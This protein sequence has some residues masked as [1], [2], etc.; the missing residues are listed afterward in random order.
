MA[1]WVEWNNGPG[2]E[3]WNRLDNLTQVPFDICQKHANPSDILSDKRAP[4]S[5]DF[6]NALVLPA[7]LSAVIV[8]LLMPFQCIRHHPRPPL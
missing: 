7:I 1:S 3:V 2:H 6:V 5:S 4:Y 8:E